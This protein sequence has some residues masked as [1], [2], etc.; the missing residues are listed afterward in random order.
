[1]KKSYY[2]MGRIAVGAF[3]SLLLCVSIN[4]GAEEG[5]AQSVPVSFHNAEEKLAGILTT[6]TEGRRHPI[7][8]MFHGFTG[9]KDELS[10]VNTDEAIFSRTARMLA[11]KGIASLRFDF[12]GSGES[13]GAWEDTTFES[14][15]S[16]AYAALD[17]IAE[18]PGVR[19]NKIGVIGY[20]QGG[21]VA[22]AIAH[23]R[24]IDSV[25]LWNPVANPYITYSTILT[26]AS[27]AEGLA[28]PNKNVALKMTLPWGAE[29][30]LKRGFFE[31]IFTIDPVAEISKYKGPLLVAVALKDMIVWP[32]PQMGNLYIDAHK[33][34][35]ELFTVDADHVFNAFV[36]TDVL[37]AAIAKNIAWF[38]DTL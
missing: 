23:D 13:D 18:I 14:Q 26:P 22:A 20:S 24:R 8:V 30:A 15:I 5:E 27:I 10:I 31:G 35:S 9:Q 34:K 33:G 6:P 11:E 12:R 21:L 16:D 1:M 2:R 28:L 3:F 37:D 36:G 7:V 25:A 29:T 19:A 17:Y 32:E 4:I 38:H